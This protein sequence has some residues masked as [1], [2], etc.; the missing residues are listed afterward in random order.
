MFSDA[1][2]RSI[3]M[4]QRPHCR[5]ETVPNGGSSDWEGLAADRVGQKTAYFQITILM[6]PFEI[7]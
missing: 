7:K 2:R 1:D 6:Q 5:A 3:E 4:E